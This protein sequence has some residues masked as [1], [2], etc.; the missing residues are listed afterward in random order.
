MSLIKN[1]LLDDQNP[2]MVLDHRLP[3]VPRKVL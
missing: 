2:K 3:S 1:S